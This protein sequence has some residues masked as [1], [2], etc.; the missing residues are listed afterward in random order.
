MKKFDPRILIHQPALY[1]IRVP[2]EFDSS[3]L[4][5]YGEL[6][7]ALD[8]NE[9]EIVITTIS[10]KLDQAGL[11]GLIRRLNSLGIPLISVNCVS[12]G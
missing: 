2:G 1:Q 4:D 11:L 3:W 9:S 8:I 6:E 5:G 7:I 10:G 12:V